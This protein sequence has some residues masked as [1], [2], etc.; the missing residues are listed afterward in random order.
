VATHKE[1]QEKELARMVP[2]GIRFP[3][4]SD[5][6]GRIGALY[7][8][9]DARQRVD[10]RGH[11]IIDPEGIVQAMEILAAPIGR[12]VAE[13]LRQLRSLQHHARTG[14]FMPCG[15]QP[16]KPTLPKREDAGAIPGKVWE[17]WKP[18]NAF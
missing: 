1:W 4:L 2:G 13:L 8:V 16:G 9:Y 3:M 12:N 11:V 14:E 6:D 18:R 7:G 5:P 17:I 15:W 10:L